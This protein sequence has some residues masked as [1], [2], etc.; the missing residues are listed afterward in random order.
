ML[1]LPHHAMHMLNSSAPI[2]TL[3][4]LALSLPSFSEKYHC[5]SL[6]PHMT[7]TELTVKA[8]TF[9]VPSKPCILLT[10]FHNIQQDLAEGDN[11]TALVLLQ[12]NPPA[13]LIYTALLLM[14]H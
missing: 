13:C 9:S 6:S 8:F 11:V 2:C 7:A 10:A 12:Q 1:A 3:H 14:T 5:S 4:W